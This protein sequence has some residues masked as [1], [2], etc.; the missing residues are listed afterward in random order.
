MLGGLTLGKARRRAASGDGRALTLGAHLRNRLVR[1]CTYCDSF[2]PAQ[3]FVVELSRGS[4]AHSPGPGS[5]VWLDVVRDFR[6]NSNRQGECT[7]CSTRW[8][9]NRRCYTKACPVPQRPSRCSQC[10]SSLVVEGENNCGGRWSDHI[11]PLR[12]TCR[13]F[14][15]WLYVFALFYSRRYCKG[16]RLNCVPG[17]SDISA[18]Q[19]SRQTAAH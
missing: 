4:A 12:A 14:P 1:N 13:V 9:S 6:H 10:L 11:P 18:E 16:R 17:D 19:E 15:Q 7:A 2:A 5:L 3:A 8:S